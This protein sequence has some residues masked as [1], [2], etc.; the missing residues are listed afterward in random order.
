MDKL[1]R[2]ELAYW[3]SIIKATGFTPEQ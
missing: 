1:Q 3:A 2:K